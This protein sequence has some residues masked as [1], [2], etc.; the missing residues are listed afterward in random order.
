MTEG[1][2]IWSRNRKRLKDRLPGVGTGKDSRTGY[3]A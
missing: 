1:W 2:P 3:L